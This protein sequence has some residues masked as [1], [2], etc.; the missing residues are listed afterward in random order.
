MF[1][2]IKKI[3]G[4]EY[5]YLVKSV[6]Q[7]KTAR[8]KVV[9]YLGRVHILTPTKPIDFQTFLNDNKL[10]INEKT[11][12]KQIIQHLMVWTV[13]QHGF[14]KDP[15]VQKK[16]LFNHGKIVADPTKLK[17]HTK[18][19]ELTLKLNEGYMNSYTLKE[20]YKIKLSKKVEE[21]RQAATLLANAFVN[22]GIKVPQDIFIDIFQRIYK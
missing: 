15:L 21:Q 5:A 13:Q 9:K 11:T 10:K 7:K 4:I 22:A 18:D 14:S 8:Q 2:R 20:L 3:K 19:R 16:W 12:I 6:W 17:I 1:I